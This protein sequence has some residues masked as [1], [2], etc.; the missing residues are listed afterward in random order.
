M[1]LSLRGNNHWQ[2]F[3]SVCIEID[4]VKAAKGCC[5]LILPTA[6][7]LTQIPFKINRFICQFFLI[8]IFP[9]QRIKSIQHSNCEG[10]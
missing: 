9:F 2:H 8:S 5:D 3:I 4:T 10:T 7:F 6:R 1:L